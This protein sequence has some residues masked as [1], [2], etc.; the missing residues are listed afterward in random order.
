M[1]QLLPHPGEIDPA[2]AYAA[3]RPRPAGRP[4]VA[5]LMAA[6]ADGAAT[7]GGRS[8]PLGGEGDRAVFRAVR[9]VADAIVV[10]AGTVRDEDYGPVRS[11]EHTAARR[12]AAGQEPHPRLVVVSG[13][14]HLNPGQRLFAETD[15]TT[16]PPLVVHPPSTPAEA[17]RRIE[18]VAELVELPA[19]VGRGVDPHA[20]VAE[21]GR[22]HLGVVVVEGGPSLNGVLVAADVVDEL[23]LTLDPMVVGGSAPRIAHAPG[24]PEARRWTTAHLMEQDGVLFWRL[25]RDRRA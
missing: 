24:E 14:L 12:V 20:L 1:R 13:R 5:A 10:G 3:I 11:P 16:P 21:L 23:C 25:V 18:A 8:G 2:E 19:A 7:V 22:R 9:A 6:S 17:R 15:G 4:W